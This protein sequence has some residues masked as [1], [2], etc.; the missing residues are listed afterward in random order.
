MSKREVPPMPPRPKPE[1]KLLNAAIGIREIIED[2]NFQG[3]DD[4]EKE[5][6]HAIYLRLLKMRSLYTSE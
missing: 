2:I 5:E 3:Y 4:S 1:N 6:L